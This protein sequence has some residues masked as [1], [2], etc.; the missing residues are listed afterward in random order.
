MDTFS[1][2]ISTCR[3]RNSLSVDLINESLTRCVCFEIEI[4][5]LTIQLKVFCTFV[6]YCIVAT[7][8]TLIFVISLPND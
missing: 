5:L 3:V 7:V 8:L 6:R 1:A 2:K 4:Q